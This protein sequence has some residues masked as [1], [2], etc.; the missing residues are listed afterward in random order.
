[1]ILLF[2]TIQ[3]VNFILSCLSSDSEL[4]TVDIS[5]VILDAFKKNAV[6]IAS[7]V[8]VQPFVKGRSNS[9]K[10][11]WFGVVGNGCKRTV[12]S[13]LSVADASGGMVDEFIF[14]II[15]VAF[16]FEGVLLMEN[17]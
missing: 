8:I 12:D 13:P 14:D 15:V 5:Q 1:M 9:K 11:F 4:E 3:M 6:F 10:I 2:L 17:G 7:E 16:V